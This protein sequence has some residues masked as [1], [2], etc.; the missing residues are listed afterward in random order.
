MMD[1]ELVQLLYNNGFYL[2]AHN[3][4]V[5]LNSLHLKNKK[6]EDTLNHFLSLILMKDSKIRHQYH[7]FK[8]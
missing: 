6:E 5:Y 7:D 4:C 2:K 3:Y 1:F 8:F